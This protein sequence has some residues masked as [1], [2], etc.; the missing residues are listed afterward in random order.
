MGSWDDGKGCFVTSKYFL[1]GLCMLCMDRVM[2]LEGSEDDVD[3]RSNSGVVY[4]GDVGVGKGD[5]W[6]LFEFE[7]VGSVD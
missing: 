2:G 6:M 5:G 7:G 3:M 4:G 1:F